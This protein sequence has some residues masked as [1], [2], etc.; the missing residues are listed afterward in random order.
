MKVLVLA[1]GSGTRLRPLTYSGAKQLVPVANRPILYYVF[2]NLAEAGIK[3][4]VVI[5]SPETGREVQTALGNGDRWGARITFV[6]QPQPGG[7]AHAVKVAAEALEG[8]DFCMF[9]G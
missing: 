9:L 7:L 3:D 5:V 1:G 2:D 4:I 8:S 6:V